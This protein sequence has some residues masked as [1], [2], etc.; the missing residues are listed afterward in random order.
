MSN[1]EV[2]CIYGH[3]GT[4]VQCDSCRPPMITDEHLKYLDELRESGETNM[5]GAGSY[6]RNEFVISKAEAS[7]ILSYWM[8]TFGEDDR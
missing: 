5:Y 3:E 4:K 8:E 1:S 7:H 6:L 2:D